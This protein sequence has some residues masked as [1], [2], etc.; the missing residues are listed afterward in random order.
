MS[1]MQMISVCRQYEEE[2][3]TICVMLLL[4]GLLIRAEPEP[5]NVSNMKYSRVPL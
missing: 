1:I 3:M 4:R 2:I 5:E